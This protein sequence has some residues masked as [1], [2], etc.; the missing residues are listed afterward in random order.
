MLFSQNCGPPHIA[1][2]LLQHHLGKLAGKAGADGSLPILL[3]RGI[4]PFVPIE[5]GK[6]TP[7]FLLQFV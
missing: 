2:A 5:N 3:D 1:F 6:L 4:G 7:H